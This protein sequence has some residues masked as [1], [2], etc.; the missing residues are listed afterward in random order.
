MIHRERERGI[1]SKWGKERDRG[2][3][4]ERVSERE[5]EAIILL[6]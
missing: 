4:K 5:R 2:R 3:E 6:C 1:R